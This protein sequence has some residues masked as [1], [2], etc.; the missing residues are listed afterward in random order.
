M[1]ASQSPPDRFG[2]TVTASGVHFALRS[3]GATAAWVSIFDDRGER[4]TDRIAL[5]RG[6]A[7]I[8]QASVPGLR[9]GARYGFRTDGPY[10]PDHGLWFDPAKL[11]ADPNAIAIDRPYRYDPRLAATRD[12]AIDTAEL[13][14]KGI[15]TTLPPIVEQRPPLLKLGGLIYELN[16]RS[17]TMLHP[18]VPEAQRGTIAAL[19]HPSIIAHFKAIGVGAIELM[20]ITA[21][22]DERHLGPLGLTNSWGYNPVGFM[23]LDPR[24]APRGLGELR[25]TVALLHEA[26]IGVILDVVFNH[27]GESDRY[28]P[29]LSLRG[30]DNRAYFRSAHD[31]PGQLTNESGCGNT[32]N[33][34]HP[35]T[36]RLVLDAARHFVGQAGIDGFRFDLAPILG[37]VH[38]GFDPGAAIFHEMARDPLLSDRLLIAEPWDIG[39]GGYQLG[40]FAAPFVEWND[41]YRDDVRRF[42]RGDPHIVGDLA[43]RLAGSSDI[44]GGRGHMHS[45]SVNFVAAHDGFTLA[46]ITAYQRKHN[47]ANGEEN[48]DGHDENLSWNNGVE[49]G[50]RQ[51]RHHCRTQARCEGDASDA[52]C[53]TGHDHD[54]R[55]RRTGPH[56]ARQQQRLRAG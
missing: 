56:P 6:P 29:T 54:H 32:L 49:G 12:S 37:R 3:E 9:E 13:M 1:A 33:C 30:I 7:D 53:I 31:E 40:N 24:L 51:P 20:P 22:I 36:R 38:D 39:A 18:D 43:T 47:Q 26:G 50:D 35:A 4:E 10:D 21:W 42:W 2:A 46:D 52:V 14:P 28:G 16:V 23:A 27:S 55:R 17:F 19:A 15:V 44:F 41:R 11:L 34:D 8:F 5:E 45:R 48:R 25:D